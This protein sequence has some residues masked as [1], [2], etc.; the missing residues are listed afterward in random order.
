MN[1]NKFIS[2]LWAELFLEL[3]SEECKVSHAIQLSTLL[4]NSNNE[5]VWGFWFCVFCVF[6]VCVF[7]T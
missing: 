2:I 6:C 1:V 4:I 3:V 7:N 5:Q